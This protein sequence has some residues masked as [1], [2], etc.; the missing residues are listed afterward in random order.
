VSPTATD[1]DPR[2]AAARLLAERDPE[3]VLRLVGELDRQ[4]GG[5][6]LERV[7]ATWQLSRAELGACFGVSR[8]AVSKWI[9]EG[10]P[11]DRAPQVADLLA[12]TDLLARYLR[13]ERIP[14]VVRRPAPNLGGSSLLE[15]VQ[16]GRSA[17]ALRL[18]RKM[19]TF[20][21]LH[22]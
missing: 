9:G 6:D 3:W 16:D 21:D 11:A 4:L 7:M 15:L 5:R 12:M 20:A 18:T 13:R 17:E 22:S 19:F 10:V 2:A 1:A 8:Q 14:A